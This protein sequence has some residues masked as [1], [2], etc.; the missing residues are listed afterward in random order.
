MSPVR[1][2]P[3]TTRPSVDEWGLGLAL[4]VAQRADCTRRAVGA[5]ILNLEGR[6]VATGYNGAPSGM[7][8]CLSA[9]ACPRGRAGYDEVAAMSD[10]SGGVGA[11]IAI[12][13]E[14]NALLHSARSEVLGGTMYVTDEPCPQCRTNLAGSGLARVVWPDGSLEFG[15]H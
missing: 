5:V 9:G 13:A 15:A 3:A 14:M 4:A 8:G 11:C 7:P 6:V 1:T 2:V 12:H 10:Y